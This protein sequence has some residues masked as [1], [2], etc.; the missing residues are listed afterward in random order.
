MARAYRERP[1]AEKWA[2]PAGVRQL[3]ADPVSGIA[4]GEWCTIS[5]PTVRREVFLADHVPPLGCPIPP[6]RTI[7]GR[8]FGWFDDLFGRGD[9]DEDEDEDE[10]DEDDE[11]EN[12]RRPRIRGALEPSRNPGNRR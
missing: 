7:F 5:T 8:S 3:R 2:V 4:L 10:D 12:R 6:R 1:A 9:R 11:R